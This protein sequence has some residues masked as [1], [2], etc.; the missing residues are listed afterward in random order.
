M[1]FYKRAVVP[2]RLCR[3]TKEPLRCAELGGADCCSALNSGSWASLNDVS[4][5]A[6]KNVLLQLSDLSRHACNVFLE[7][8]S[9]ASSVVH[10]SAALQQRL[11]TLQDAVR[12]LDPKRIT[13]LPGC[14]RDPE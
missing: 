10:R 2:Q 14:K 11:D 4:R 8:Q 5:T 6:L 7:I 12:K 3:L 13:I 1:P 9:E